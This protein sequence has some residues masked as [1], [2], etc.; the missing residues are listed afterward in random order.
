[1]LLPY[2]MNLTRCSSV[3]ILGLCAVAALAQTKQQ[4]PLFTKDLVIY[5]VATKSFTSPAGP[6]SGT[7]RS[8]AARLPYLKNLGINCIWLTGHNLA[9]NKHF[10]GIWTQY[11][12]I[13]PD[14]LEPSLGT[15]QEFNALIKTAHE[16]GIK[17]VLDVITHGVMAN[18]SLI[19][20]HPGWFKGGSWG[21]TDY[22]WK[23]NH[24]D[25]DA[26]WVKTWTDYVL[27]YDVDGF[28]LDVS[29]YRPDLWKRIKEECAQARKPIFVLDEGSDPFSEG[30]FDFYQHHAR[31]MDHKDPVMDSS[32]LYLTDVASYF[33]RDTASQNFYYSIQLSCHDNG[34]TS[35]PP[36]VN[37]YVAEGSRSLFGYSC[38]FTPSI[39]VFMSGEEFNA[40]YVPLPRLSPDLFSKSRPGDSSRWL[41][42]SWMK[43]DQLEDPNKRAMFNDVKHMLAIRDAEKDII[44]A[45][46][47]G[48]KQKNILPAFVRKSPEMVPVPYMMWNKNTALLIASNP[49]TE[50]DKE[51]IIDLPLN[52]ARLTYKT[53]KVS[54]LWEGSQPVIMKAA[55][56]RFFKVFIKKD[57]TPK[58]GLAVYKFEGI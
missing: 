18:S 12:V 34:W 6:E 25:L 51:M 52:K 19:S 56:L 33:Q 13:R 11:A 10:Y 29:I 58:G 45:F 40:D 31:F 48:D 4:H 46:Q 57:K 43:W 27:K 21:M 54:N 41:Y 32:S 14:S 22:D 26:W 7:F 39:P 55:D 49:M 8:T 44:H 35:F 42:G 24:K 9:D 5:E 30:A 20:Q 15:P 1:M 3:F 16:N 23:G 53:Y 37:P 28:R 47:P 38:L 17:I 2:W 36:G 50:K